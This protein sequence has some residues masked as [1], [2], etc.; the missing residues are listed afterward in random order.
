MIGLENNRIAI[1]VNEEN[2]CITSL[3]DKQ[4]K[5]EYMVEGRLSA[6]FRIENSE[7]FA[8]EFQTVTCEP[9]S[10]LPD[11]QGWIL[12]WVVKPGLRVIGKMYL[13]RDANEI[14]FYCEVDNQTEDKIISLEY[15]IISDLST[16]TEQGDNDYVAHSFATG[17]QIHNPMKHFDIDGLG[18]RYM[19][20]PEGFSGSTM[21]FFTYYGLNQGGLYFAALDGEGY[22]K[23]LNFYKNNHHLL[24]ASF[25]HGCEDIGAFKGMKTSYPIIVKMLDGRGWYEAADIYRA[26]AEQQMWCAKGKL[27][28]VHNEDKS[29]WLLEDMGAATFGINAGLNRTLWINE[30]HKFI[31]TPIFHILGPDW[32]HKTQNFYNGIPGGMDDWFPTRFDQANLQCMKSYGDKYAPFEFDY[33]F[34]VNGADGERGREALQKFPESL[35]SID[36]YKF[37]LVCP[38]DPYIRE[39]HTMRDEALQRNDDVDS[40][41]YDIS[42]NNILKT[43]TDES[44]GHTIGASKAITDAYKH[45]YVQTKAAMNKVA[46]R[47]IPMGTEMINEIFIDVL[48]Y[49][50][51]RAGGQPAAPLEGWNI[52][53]LLVSGAAEL[54]PMFT[55]VYHE[56]GAIRI[57]GW[58]KLVEE[59][60]A[61]YYYT[62]A[63]TYL[64]GGLYELNYEYSPMEAIDGV[65]NSAEEH[66]YIF[67]Q[68]GYVFSEE[69]ARYLGIFASLRTGMGNKYWAYGRM[70]RPIEFESVDVVLDWFQYNC[71][72]N[73]KEYN[74]SGILTVDAVIHSAWSYRDESIGLFFANVTDIEQRVTVKLDKSRF[75]VKISQYKLTLPDLSAFADP[76]DF[77][78]GRIREIELAIPKRSVILLELN[79]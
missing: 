58:G 12:T 34:N 52:R 20:Y 54:I 76:H 13:Y 59:I 19:P 14:H 73:F 26:W 45:N 18:L 1:T 62:V 10:T 75:D 63:R 70:L 46:D 11:Q 53:P 66:Y 42:A 33:L 47:Y 57:D 23:W 7:G 40:I 68:R 4:K 51:A 27:V 49:Y 77:S 48:D 17:F 43:C 71:D 8:S 50:Q 38:V 16:I 2:G 74:D 69:R 60:G 15:P 32:A 78:D 44:H 3:Y 79:A 61:L 56:Y 28:D 35:K 72:K 6:P 29:V 55:Y 65:E 31:D 64:W 30:Y 67:D 9:D 24:E 21:Q 36:K 37:S 25:I 41:Y 22:A 5:Q 39:L